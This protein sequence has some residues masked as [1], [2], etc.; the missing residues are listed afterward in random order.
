MRRL[1]DGRE[2][3]RARGEGS[4]QLNRVHMAGVDK[5]EEALS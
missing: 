2:K 3:E 4:E 5:I 1:G